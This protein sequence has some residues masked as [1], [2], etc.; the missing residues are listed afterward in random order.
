MRLIVVRHAQ[1]AVDPE[2]PQGS[3]PLTDAGR[4]AARRLA[5]NLDETPE[6]VVCSPERK[7]VETAEPI[8]TRFDLALTLDERLREADRPWIDSDY[9]A[10][11]RQ[12]L[13][14][15]PLDGWEPQKA[16]TE[17]WDEAIGQATSN[18]HGTVILVG[19]GLA[20]TAWASDRFGIEPVAFWT[21]LDFPCIRQFTI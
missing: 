16:V 12:W 14:G 9:P 19:H 3:W 1:P 2:T 13:S 7:A 15:E 10:L 18:S 20:M 6:T 4:A 17:R 8:A 11:A 21:A 5:Q